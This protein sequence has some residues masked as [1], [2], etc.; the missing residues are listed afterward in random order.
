MKQHKLTI[1]GTLALVIGPAIIVGLAVAGD[2]TLPNPPET[3]A[4]PAQTYSDA[5]IASAT[6]TAIPVP[7]STNRP[8]ISARMVLHGR[9]PTTKQF[10]PAGTETVLVIPDV[11]AAAAQVPS[12]GVAMQ[13]LFQATQ[14][15][16]VFEATNAPAQGN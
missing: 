8:V 16:I 7:G 1:L 9:S 10:A 14:A 6:F 11:E 12:L 5:W 4:T 13:A 2:I 3:P 15:W